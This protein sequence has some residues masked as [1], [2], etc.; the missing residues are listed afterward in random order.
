[1]GFF[2]SQVRR[3]ILLVLLV[4]LTACQSGTPAAKT[5]TPTPAQTNTPSFTATPQATTTPTLVPTPTLAKELQVK[6]ADL[7]GQ[8]IRFWHPLSGEAGGQMERLVTQFNLTNTWGVRVTMTATGGEG[9]LIGAVEQA[10]AAELPDVVLAASEDIAYWRKARNLPVDLNVYLD[11]VDW[12]FAKGAREGYNP[13]FWKQDSADN[14]QL[15]IPALRTVTGLIYNKS[16]AAD[17]KFASPPGSTQD[18]LTQ[19]CAAAKANNA[20][21][22]RQGT[23][24]WM[25]DTSAL[26]DLSW[27]ASFGPLTLPSKE[28]DSWKFDQPA[29]LAALHYLRGMQ[30]KGCLWVAKNP[31]P[32]IYFGSRS[33][34]FYT[35]SLQD[36][37]LQAGYLKK[38]DSKDEWG[39]IPFPGANGK[40]IVFSNGYSYSVLRSQPL[41]QMA[42]WLFVRWM[43]SPDVQ[44]RLASVWLSMPVSKQM[45]TELGSAA[46]EEPWKSI[47][48]LMGSIQ[49]APSLASWRVVRR[50]LEDAF[51]QLFNVQSPDQIPQILTTLDEMSAEQ[52][53]SAP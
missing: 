30:E 9:A 49:P 11:Q 37:V 29:S 22:E 27:M 53:R 23:G 10:K 45:L 24:G 7:K 28:S 32:Q 42:A 33:A 46:G 13:V 3:L 38:T 1:M 44:V 16:F 50:P 17:L 25:L 31:T 52:L 40:G 26:S 41:K 43:S 21:F 36:Y 19:A 18:L 6:V 14:V 34:L 35:A 5:A 20:F 47:L 8:E 2:R 51:W 4:V 12:G 39:M 48:P 15:A